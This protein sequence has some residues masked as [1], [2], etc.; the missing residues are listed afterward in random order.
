MVPWATKKTWYEA[1]CVNV[2][3][4]A[5]AFSKSDAFIQYISSFLVYFCV[6]A[7][8][9]VESVLDLLFLSFLLLIFL[10]V[11]FSVESE[12]LH[13]FY[14]LLRL[15]TAHRL[16]RHLKRYAP[17]CRIFSLLFFLFSSAIVCKL[18]A[19]QYNLINLSN[20][21]SDYCVLAVIT[22]TFFL[23]V[24]L[25]FNEWRIEKIESSDTNTSGVYWIWICELKPKPEQIGADR[26]F[27][28]L[29]PRKPF[30][31]SPRFIRYV[32]ICQFPHF[33]DNSL[34]SIAPV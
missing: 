9:A 15:P 28:D 33:Y 21:K 7:H 20:L 14:L 8:G 30:H 10:S 16:C 23:F 5:L 32:K 2:F 26:G 22:E 34:L 13:K 19:S 29:W 3:F 11:F 17:R 12:I 18:W 6:F 24:L 1:P 4:F 31:I 25:H 27:S